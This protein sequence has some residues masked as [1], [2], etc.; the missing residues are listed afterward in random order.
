MS[1]TKVV[2]NDFYLRIKVNGDYKF[3]VC[4]QNTDWD[5]S[6]EPITVLCKTTGPYPEILPGGTKSGSL[7]FTGAYI[8]D[9]DE[10]ISF[11]D[12][13]Q[14]LGEIVEYA[15]GGIEEGDDNIE[16]EAHVSNITMGAN[17]NEA[18]TFGAT[19]TFSKEPVQSKVSS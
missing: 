1:E 2:G 3:V 11:F 17:T 18:I 15:W 12:L 10:D 14:S 7:S 5:E 8:K 13:R 4:E 19:L 9:P 16:G 6:A